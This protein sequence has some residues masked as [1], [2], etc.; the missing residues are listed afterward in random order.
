MR[1]WRLDPLTAFLAFFLM[2][3]ALTTS[4]FKPIREA[5]FVWTMIGGGA[6]VGLVVGLIWRSTFWE[7]RDK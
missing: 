7:G 5:G 3:I 2:G 1:G 4:D 6:L